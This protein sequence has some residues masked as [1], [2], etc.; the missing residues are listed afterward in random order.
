MLQKTKILI[1]IFIILHFWNC[2]EGSGAGDK[3]AINAYALSLLEKD[4]AA[5]DKCRLSVEIMN[6]CIGDGYQNQFN[7]ANMCENSKLK[8]EAEYATLI[9]CASGKV[10][11][12][13]CN[14]PQN[15]VGDARI[16]Y[17]NF[18]KSCNL[19]A[20]GKTETG[21]IIQDWYTVTYPTF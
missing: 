3:T 14:M 1:I 8:T 5:K 13:Y 2:T 12:T 7:P 15:R 19:A 16:A 9:T 4:S 10:N 20:D 18:F 11:T 21:I 6:Q 17:T